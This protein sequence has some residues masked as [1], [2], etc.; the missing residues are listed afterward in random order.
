[1]SQFQWA[2]RRGMRL[3]RTWKRI[4]TDVSGGSNCVLRACKRIPRWTMEFAGNVQRARMLQRFDLAKRS[5]EA[6]TDTKSQQMFNAWVN[7]RPIRGEEKRCLEFCTRRRLYELDR[8]L[9]APKKKIV[10]NIALYDAK[11]T[12]EVGE[13]SCSSITR[14]EFVVGY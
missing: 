5:W 11:R 13:T 8:N 12:D 14:R 9:L 10:R 2:H 7:R 3:N 1:M 6:G 4:K